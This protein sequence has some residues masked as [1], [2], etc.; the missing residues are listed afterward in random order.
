MKSLLR[1]ITLGAALVA[2]G[3]YLSAGLTFTIDYVGGDTVLTLT[4]GQTLDI[5]G[6]TLD[7]GSTPAILKGSVDPASGKFVTGPTTF[8]GDVLADVF[9]ESLTGLISGPSNFGTGGFTQADYGTGDSVGFDAG[10]AESL[11]IDTSLLGSVT[12]DTDGNITGG[13]L[14]SF[15]TT[16]TAVW[17]GTTNAVADLGISGGTYTWIL[18]NDTIVLTAV[19]EPSTYAAIGFGAAA[20]LAFIY[21]RRLHAKKAVAEE[22]AE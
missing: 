11:F 15:G 19:P 10:L 4:G 8:S 6:L 14:V 12:T 5:T 13:G 1:Y 17:S 16:S 20:L 7:Q 22:A 2:T 21:R 9:I 3:S 18:P